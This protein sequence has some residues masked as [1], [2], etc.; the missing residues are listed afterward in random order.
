MRPST[1]STATLLLI[2]S[3]ALALPCFGF[4]AEVV[5]ISDGDTIRVLASG[6]EI[7]IRLASI[8]CPERKQPF[9]KKAKRFARDIVA[10]KIVEIE[11]VTKDRYGRTVAWVIADGKNV[12][13][14]LVRAGLA[15][16][17]RKYAPNDAELEQ[18][19]KEAREAG[20]GLWVEPN[21]MP[22]WEWRRA[23]REKRKKL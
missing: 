11:P 22:P 1:I 6:K 3:L 5:G 8:D 17:Y 2:L 9:G 20:R 16:W 23:K 4:Q 15:W 14:E 21:Q 12:N 13:K 18:L 19:E 10:G 7:K